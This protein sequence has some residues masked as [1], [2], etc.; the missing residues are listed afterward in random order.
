MTGVTI[1]FSSL[2]DGPPTDAV[3]AA[4]DLSV[5]FVELTMND[6]PPS[7][8]REEAGRIMDAADEAGVDLVVHLPHGGEDHMVGS[9]DDDTRDRSIAQFQ[10]SLEAAASIGATKAV[11]HVDAAAHRLLLE[12]DRRDELVRVVND[13]A[14][15]AARHGIDLCVENMR[16]MNRRR[17][18]PDDVARLARETA[19]SMTLDTGHARTVGYSDR[20]IVDFLDR[21][22]DVVSHVHLN[23]TRGSTDDHLPFGAGT[24]DFRSLF[25]ALPDAWSGTFALEVNVP[26]YDYVA[27]SVDRLT[28]V[29]E[30]SPLDRA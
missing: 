27:V 26:T 5:D 29:L 12:V 13:L 1:G 9:S 19:G 11:I 30:S 20:D 8:L 4:N 25:A 22:G 3:H 21:H 24:T 14:T 15:D 2:G 23:D 10:T 17:L 28:S 18:C 7:R 6:Y 16:G